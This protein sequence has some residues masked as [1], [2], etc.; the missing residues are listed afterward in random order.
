MHPDSSSCVEVQLQ[1]LQEP[2]I[3]AVVQVERSAH[4]HPWSRTHFVDVVQAG[5]HAQMLLA[6]Q[7]VLGYFVAM[8]GVDEVHL[9]NFTVAPQYQ[10]QGWGRLM[11][12]ALSLWA[13]GK[14]A[15]SVW[16]EVRESNQRALQVY[17]R[18]GFCRVAL[19]KQYYCAN[20]GQRENAVVM[21][22]NLHSPTCEA[23]IDLPCPLN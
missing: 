18:Q 17:E 8:L 6:Q 7:S 23:E 2:W 16:L 1:P 12:Q 13:R 20:H 14:Q 11:L 15:S 22:L 4:V 10:R 21:R 5:Y 3:D 19:R 9:L